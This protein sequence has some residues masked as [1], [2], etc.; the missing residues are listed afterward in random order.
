ML[1]GRRWAPSVRSQTVQFRARLIF[2][3][4]DAVWQLYLD[5]HKV[6]LVEWQYV[7]MRLPRLRTT[8]CSRL[9]PRALGFG[10]GI[11]GRML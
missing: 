3:P 9:K 2:F 10:A 5:R 8:A 1:V 6:I 11:L 4:K 7:L